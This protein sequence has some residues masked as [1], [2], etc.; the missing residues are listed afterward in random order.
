MGDRLRADVP[1]RYV[2]TPTSSTQPCIP[3]GSLN[4]VPVLIGWGKGEN[5]TYAGWQ[6]TLCDPIWRVSCRSGETCC[7]LR[8]QNVL[9]RVVAQAQST[10]SSVHIRRDLHWLPVNH[11]KLSLLTWKAL[12]TAELSYLAEL[13]SP[14]VPARTLRSSNT[15]LLAIPTHVTSHFSSRSFFASAPSTWNSLPV[16]IF[17]LQRNSRPLSVI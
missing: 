15:C 7:D 16:Y 6:V 10:I 13:I 1:P 2:T 14:Y 8:V 12:H 17:I 4:R 3:P 11:R 9:A 5:V